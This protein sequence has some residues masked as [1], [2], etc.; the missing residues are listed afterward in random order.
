MRINV[1][2]ELLTKLLNNP[3]TNQDL[4]QIIRTKFSES[5]ITSYKDIKSFED[6]CEYLG[7][8]ELEAFE[9]TTNPRLISQ[10]KL[11][12][13][14]KALNEGWKPDFTDTRQRK[15][16]NYFQIL[17]GSFVFTDTDY[18]FSFI[19]TPSTLYFKDEQTAIYCKDN[20]FDLY[21]QY[22]CS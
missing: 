22:Y 5:T 11:E 6:A 1:P 21:K 15:Y 7:I 14:I 12:T 8:T 10:L 2:I 18:R 3:E 16:Y 17:N 13:I 9:G 19:K 20:F 4:K